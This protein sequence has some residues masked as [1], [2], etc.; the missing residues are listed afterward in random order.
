MTDFI[1]DYYFEFSLATASF[2]LV[3]IMIGVPITQREQ[4]FKSTLL[5]ISA[6][7]AITALGMSSDIKHLHPIGFAHALIAVTIA[8]VVVKSVKS[9]FAKL[10]F[11]P[12]GLML[13]VMVFNLLHDGKGLEMFGRWVAA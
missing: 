1:F 10:L 6:Y 13:I 7:I 5:T 2:A 12:C 11:A 3:L 4:K 8:L 9:G